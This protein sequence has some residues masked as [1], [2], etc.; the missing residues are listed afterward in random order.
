MKEKNDLTKLEFVIN[1]NENIVIQRFFNVK[2]YNEDSNRSLELYDYVKDLGDSL[3]EKMKDGTHDYLS[4]HLS[5]IIMD[6]QSIETSKTDENEFF[7]LS[8]KNG[9]KT[10]C[11]RSWNAKLYP[12]KVRYTLDI[13]PRVKNI[14]KDLTDIFSDKNLSYEYM[15]YNL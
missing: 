9:D 8:I 5:Q 11:Q 15:D 3:Q 13:R 2:G 14:L 4:N 1:L 12:P 7:Y 10:I 6:P